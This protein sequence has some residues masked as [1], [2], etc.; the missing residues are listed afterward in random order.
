MGGYQA[1]N[2]SRWTSYSVLGD[3]YTGGNL[4]TLDPRDPS[5]ATMDADGDGLDNLC[6]Y[7]WGNLLETVL[8]EG[9]PTHRE[10]AR[11]AL[12]WTK[13]ITNALRLALTEPIGKFGTFLPTN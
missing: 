8:I 13:S 2:H 10:N 1:S 6:E 4:W 5:D 9:L 7:M 11:A 3:V 12:N